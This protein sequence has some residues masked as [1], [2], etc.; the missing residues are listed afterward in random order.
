MIHIKNTTV[1]VLHAKCCFD[2][3]WTPYYCGW[4]VVNPSQP[5]DIVFFD[6]SKILNWLESCTLLQAGQLTVARVALVCIYSCFSTH[7]STH[8]VSMLLLSISMF[9]WSTMWWTRKWSCTCRVPQL[10]SGCSSSNRSLWSCR[11]NNLW[12]SVAQP[13]PFQSFLFFLLS[14]IS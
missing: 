3:T 14:D 5:C 12:L 13:V 6:Q 11:H 1:P 9:M 8:V 7:K 10:D 2:G 4:Y